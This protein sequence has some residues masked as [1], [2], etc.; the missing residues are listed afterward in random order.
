MIMTA[1]PASA[2]AVQILDANGAGSLAARI[3]NHDPNRI[4][5]AGGFISMAVG[6][7]N[8][9]IAIETN[10][11]QGQIFVRLNENAPGKNKAFTLFLT[12]AKGRD[13]TLLLK[14]ANISGESLIIRP[15]PDRAQSKR[16]V[17]VE[18]REARLKRLVRAMAMD[19][20]PRRCTL[21]EESRR[22]PL[23]KGTDFSMERSMQCGDF[24]V[25]RYRLSNTSDKEIRLAEQELYGDGIAAVSVER[26]HLNHAGVISLEPGRSTMV[27]IV[28]ESR[29]G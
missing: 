8:G 27:I 25:E 28:R 18:R 20:V 21:S 12:D 19:N 11:K 9:R 24:S 22:A 15:R 23:W 6:P 17:G 5:I 2:W 13:Y 14:P 3:S 16:P 1:A 10:D 7:R 26:M 4:R 29:H